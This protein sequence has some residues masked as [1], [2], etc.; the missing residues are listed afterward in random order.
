M[1]RMIKASQLELKQGNYRAIS[2]LLYSKVVCLSLASSWANQ[3]IVLARIDFC[4][5]LLGLHL[6]STKF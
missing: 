4:G 2:P 3:G 5:I 1:I 6:F